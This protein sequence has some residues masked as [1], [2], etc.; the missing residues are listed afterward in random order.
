MKKYAVLNPQ[1]GTYQYF[2][3]RE[4][5]INGAVDTAFNVYLAHTHNQPFANITVNE[6]G[7]ETWHALNGEEMLNPN[8]LSEAAQRMADMLKSFAEAQ[9]L[10]VTQL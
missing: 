9:Q 5:A 1:T 2:D 6:D 4:A 8:N 3:T 10:Q 7:S